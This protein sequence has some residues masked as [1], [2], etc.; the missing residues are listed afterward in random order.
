MSNREYWQERFLSLEEAEHR[1]A[2]D[3]YKT[4]EKEFNKA[5]KALTEKIDSWYARLAKNNGVT[6]QEARK[7]L[8][9][10]ELEEFKWSVEEYIQKGRENALNQSFMK[11]LE[12]ASARVHINCLEALQTEL[13]AEVELLYKNYHDDFSEFISDAYEDGLYH[14]VFEIEKGTGVTSSLARIDKLKLDKIIYKP[15]TSDGENF[16][17]R[18]WKSK[19]QLVNKLYTQLTQ[20]CINGESV[21]KVAEQIVKFNKNFDKDIHTAKMQAKRLI[22]TENAYFGTLARKDAFKALE[23]SEYEIVATLDSHTSEICQMMDGKVFKTSELEVGV[24]APPFH[25]NCRTTT[26]PYFNDEF[27]EG[28]TRASR[29]E[30]KTVQAESMTYKEWAKKYLVKSTKEARESYEEYYKQFEDI[31]EI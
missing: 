12:N 21:D 25:V 14:S 4:I 16:S 5:E 23:V 24:N 10:N 7:L 20:S 8:T 11:E 31:E 15:W 9:D 13:R 29:P 3:F 17:S 26:V 18:I 22:N 19:G 6:L 28:E 27:T 2:E 1:K 30:D